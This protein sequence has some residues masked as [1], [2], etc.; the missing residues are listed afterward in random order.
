MCLANIVCMTDVSYDTSL[1]YI[2]KKNITGFDKSSGRL[3]QKFIVYI[4]WW[5]YVSNAIMDCVFSIMD[6]VFSMKDCVFSIMDCVFSIID[7]VFSIIDCVFSIM[8]CVFSIIDCVFSIMDCVF[9]IMDYVF[10]IMD[11]VFSIINC[12]FSIMDCVFS[13]LSSIYYLAFYFLN[14]V[15]N[16]L[17]NILLLTRIYTT[18]QNTRFIFMC[19]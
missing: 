4:Y 11:C 13:M 10:S 12:V 5:K 14:A 1:R 17:S 7:C 19:S 9:S 2:M 8:D 3:T 16:L 18:S 6:S 15:I